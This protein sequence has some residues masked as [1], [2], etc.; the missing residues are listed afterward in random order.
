MQE[1]HDPSPITL[2]QRSLPMQTHQ[3]VEPI[4]PD[5]L[6]GRTLGFASFEAWA[7]S[8]PK[9]Q[10][11]RDE[12]RLRVIE[13]DGIGMTQREIGATVGV[14]HTTVSD[15]LA[16]VGGKP[17]TPE[18]DHAPPAAP[19]GGKPPTSEPER[20]KASEKTLTDCDHYPRIGFRTRHSALSRLVAARTARS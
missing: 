18:P 20:P 8:I 1:H 3:A 14:D 5:P 19:A 6:C 13:L 9:Y 15:D 2:R 7:K 17:P 4:Y 11:S 16:S 10:L 12:R